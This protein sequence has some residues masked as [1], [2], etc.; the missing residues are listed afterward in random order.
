MSIGAWCRKAIRVF[1]PLA[2][3]RGLDRS[4]AACLSRAGCAPHILVVYE[5]EECRALVRL[6]VEAFRSNVVCPNKHT[7][8]ADK[9]YKGRLLASETYIG[10][11]VEA[12]ESG[13]F[14]ADLPCQF[15]TQPDAYQGLMDRCAV[16]SA[17]CVHCTLPL[18]S[19]GWVVH[20]C[21]ALIGIASCYA[22]E[23]YPC[24]CTPIAMG[25]I[26]ASPELDALA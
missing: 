13:I 7:D 6:Q 4:H 8:G 26:C 25:V 23:R 15:K 12:L 9:L 16:H 24:K 22:Q 5:H 11:K 14:R 17:A 20:A 1:F 2:F 3:I 18:Q 21:A 10:G 19:S